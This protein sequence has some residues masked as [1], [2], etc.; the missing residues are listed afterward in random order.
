M[1][2]EISKIRNVNRKFSRLSADCMML[3]ITS[4]STKNVWNRYSQE[5]FYKNMA[6]DQLRRISSR[7]AVVNSESELDKDESSIFLKVYIELIVR[8]VQKLLHVGTR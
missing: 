4:P 3:Y 8:Y 1:N 7:I 5:I 2:S 6:S